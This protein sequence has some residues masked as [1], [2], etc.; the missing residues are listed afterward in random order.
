MPHP[1]TAADSNGRPPRAAPRAGANPYAIESPT[2]RTFGPRGPPFTGVHAPAT[3]TASTSASDAP[4]HPSRPRGRA[5]ALTLGARTALVVA[6]APAADAVHVEERP[7]REQAHEGEGDEREA[8]FALAAAGVDDLLGQGRHGL[9]AHALLGTGTGPAAW[10][11]ASSFSRQCNESRPRPNRTEN[12]KNATMGGTRSDPRSR[13]RMMKPC[14]FDCGSHCG[15]GGG[16]PNSGSTSMTSQYSAA[17][18]WG[19]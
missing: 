4:R 18:T 5:I 13:S 16:R 9:D 7:H 2:S 15:S 10:S 17:A 8:A 14:L 11:A 3:A 1:E 6:L 19:G 12:M